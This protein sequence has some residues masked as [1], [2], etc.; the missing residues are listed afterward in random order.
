MT[1]EV[2]V[3]VGIT[4]ARDPLHGS[5]R[6]D[7]PHAALALGNNAHA[8]ERIGMA[9][10]RQRQPA[11][12]KAPHTSQSTRPFCLR[13]DSARCQSRPSIHRNLGRSIK[14]HG[15]KVDEG[16]SRELL[17]GVDLR[18]VAAC[19]FAHA[20]V[21]CV[22]GVGQRPGGDRSK[23]CSARCRGLRNSSRDHYPAALSGL[24]RRRNS[25]ESELRATGIFSAAMESPTPPKRFEHNPL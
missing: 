5:G 22:T 12:D 1:T 14:F 8:A 19:G 18:T 20:G 11:V 16:V 21:N 24:H 15:S 4:I 6:A 13:C 7:F 2:R 25:S 9:D 23:S 3:G 17:H 10:S